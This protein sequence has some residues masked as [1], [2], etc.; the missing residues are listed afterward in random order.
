MTTKTELGLRGT[1]EQ[2]CENLNILNL[3]V[4]KDASYKGRKSTLVSFHMH[5]PLGLSTGIL[6]FEIWLAND[7]TLSQDAKANLVY[8]YASAEAEA[9]DGLDSE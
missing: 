1:I 9:F 5:N 6:S 8:S 3:V 2:R 7:L 4:D